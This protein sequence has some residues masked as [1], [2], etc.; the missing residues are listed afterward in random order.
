MTLLR[1]YIYLQFMPPSAPTNER[2]VRTHHTT[3]YMESMKLVVTQS[4]REKDHEIINEAQSVCGQ[5]TR[6]MQLKETSYPCCGARE[7]NSNGRIVCHRLMRLV[8]YLLVS[9]TPT[10]QL[11]MWQQACS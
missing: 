5:K 6:S 1:R 2:K 10:K 11:A 9:D 7:G 4:C 3:L 8:T